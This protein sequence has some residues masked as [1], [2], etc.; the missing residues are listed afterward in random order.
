MEKRKKIEVKNIYKSFKVHKRKYGL[1]LSVLVN[2]L[3]NRKVEKRDALKDVSFDV[4][5]GEILGIIGNNG[6]GKSTL[7]RVISGIFI[8]DKGDIKCDG[9]TIYLSGFGIFSDKNMTLVE[10]IYLYGAIQGFKKKEIDNLVPAILRQAKLEEYS[11]EPLY[12]LSDGM[13]GRFAYNVAVNFIELTKPE[14]MVMDEVFS[15]GGGDIKF[16]EQGE[17]KM[18]DLVKSDI[19]VVLVSHQMNT[20]RNICDRA[21]WIDKGEVKMIGESNEV[22]D[23]Y[24]EFNKD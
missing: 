19:T 13:R 24:I 18:V 11:D 2:F 5:E 22:V 6:S 12:T 9:K 16:Q 3:K 23:A 10:N 15:A 17:D 8:P 14:I 1:A 20:I 4:Y 21:V 7:L